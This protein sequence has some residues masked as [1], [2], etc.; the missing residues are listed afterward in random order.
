VAY[1][2]DLKIRKWDRLFKAQ[3][4]L[5]EILVGA[6]DFSFFGHQPLSFRRLFG[7][8]VS[9]ESF[10]ESDFPGASDLKSFLGT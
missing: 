5:Y 6:A 9:L 4:T 3:Q 7:K 1:N 8:D 2:N 10:L